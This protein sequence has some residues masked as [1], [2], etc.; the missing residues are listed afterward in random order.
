MS[1]SLSSEVEPS[2]SSPAE[3]EACVLVGGANE[4]VAHAED[5]VNS[6]GLP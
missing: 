1:S 6:D 4:G 2:C 3:D 5:S